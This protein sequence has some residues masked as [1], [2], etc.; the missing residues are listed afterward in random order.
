[1]K[2]GGAGQNLL[3]FLFFFLP[4]TVAVSVSVIV[5]SAIQGL[6]EGKEALVSVVMLIVCFVLSLAAALVEYIRHK[7]QVEKRVQEILEGTARM[8]KGD[9]S[10]RFTSLNSWGYY[11]DFDRIK[12]NLNTLA[13]EL[14]K[15]ETLHTDFIAS[16]SHEIKTPLA[17]LGSHAQLLAKG[18]LTP[19]KT[20]YHAER[21]VQASE[22]LSTL[23]TNILK[24]NKLESG[25][26]LPEYKT[27]D[28]TESLTEH[29]LSLETVIVAKG[30]ALETDIQDGV[31]I[32]A[33]DGFWDILCG[34]LLSNAVKFTDCGGTVR[35]SLAT[36]GR[37]TVLSVSDTGCGFC[38]KDGERIFDKF[39][40][41][42]T[43]RRS[44][45]NGLGLALVKKV[46]ERMGGEISVVSKVG[47]GS[48]FT[49]RLQS[50]P[51]GDNV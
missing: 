2:K 3:G 49:V 16:V 7:V 1:M 40:Q 25:E 15:T 6:G 46:I 51:Q 38:A 48:T 21:L 29:I 43:S 28:A 32:S 45:G 44:E 33:P 39:Y 4:I 23:V 10:V 31:M 9:F 30:L 34:N 22:R 5:F 27:V 26:V 14:S 13:K 11:D 47:K 24:L 42:D 41:A 18:N 19:E 8:A 17:M 36:D 20:K 37:E 12:E 50:E 35:V